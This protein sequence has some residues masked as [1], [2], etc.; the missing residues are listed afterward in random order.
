M[1]GWSAHR[2]AGPDKPVLGAEE[3]FERW[4]AEACRTGSRV[5]VGV[6]KL[7]KTRRRASDKIDIGEADR[8]APKYT[9]N[10]GW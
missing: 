4:F 3:A 1:A 2:K 6:D 7:P 9:E 10:D 8:P 5:D